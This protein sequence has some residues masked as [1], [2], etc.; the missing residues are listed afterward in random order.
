M[1]LL[2]RIEWITDGQVGLTADAQQTA[3]LILG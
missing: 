1:G 3:S 2:L